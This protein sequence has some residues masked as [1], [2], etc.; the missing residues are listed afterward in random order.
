M[1][2]LAHQPGEVWL[3]G[4]LLTF[5]LT[6][7][8]WGQL[9]RVLVCFGTQVFLHFYVFLDPK[10]VRVLPVDCPFVFSK[11]H[12]SY[13]RFPGSTLKP[14]LSGGAAA[15]FLNQS[16]AALTALLQLLIQSGCVSTRSRDTF[17]QKFLPEVGTRSSFSF[18]VVTGNWIQ[19]FMPTRLVPCH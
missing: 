2:I 17:Y 6:A 9:L 11:S 16:H 3:A 7:C 1:V 5:S 14:G 10:Q 18:F 8:M 13:R 4:I 12:V 19:D 15:G